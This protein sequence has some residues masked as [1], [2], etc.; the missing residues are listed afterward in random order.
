MIKIIERYK[1]KKEKKFHDTIYNEV[2]SY[3][4]DCINGAFYV[5]DNNYHC[6]GRDCMVIIRRGTPCKFNSI[7][8]RK[9]G[10]G[11]IFQIKFSYFAKEEKFARFYYA[12]V[13][14]E[15]IRAQIENF[16]NYINLNFTKISNDN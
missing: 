3:I 15:N 5:T 8:E 10:A 12:F 9:T 6:E 7:S 13:P 4:K 14:N 1:E 16:H 11:L 2:F